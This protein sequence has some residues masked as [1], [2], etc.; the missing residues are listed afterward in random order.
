LKKL[1]TKRLMLITPNRKYLNDFYGYAKKP[2]VGP[3]AG[4][5]PH[6]NIEETCYILDSFR[7][8]KNN[9][10]VILK[11]N[12]KMIGTLGMHKCDFTPSNAN[13][14]EI[15]YAFDDDYWNMGYATE[16][17]KAVIK[18]LF[19]E[20][21]LDMIGVSHFPGNEASKKVILKTKFKFYRET[22]DIHYQ[23]RQYGNTACEYILTKNE[24]IKE[25][26]NG[27]W[28]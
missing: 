20:L 7:K 9:W 25:K 1:I 27:T 18:Y 5:S 2:T 14:Y 23:F 8:N 26:E 24:Y 17:V 22:S 10:F 21:K 15:G 13:S 6:K 12:G 19:E 16:A 3:N 11:E 28:D 4:W